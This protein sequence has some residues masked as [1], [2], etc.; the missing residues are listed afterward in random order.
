MADRS[1]QVAQLAAMQALADGAALQRA[2]PTNA[3]GL[4]DRLKAGVEQLSGVSLDGVRVHYDSPEPARLAANAYT[5]GAEIHVGRGNERYLPHETWHVVQQAQGRARPTR[6]AG[7]IGIDDSRELEREADVMGA[8]AMHLAPSTRPTAA[9]LATVHTASPVA[10]LS[11]TSRWRWS[12]YLQGLP[13]NA[14]TCD[15]I[16][17]GEARTTIEATLDAHGNVKKR[18]IRLHT[19]TNDAW[20]ELGSVTIDRARVQPQ[21][22]MPGGGL[23]PPI[24]DDHEL[25]L[26]TAAA[27]GAGNA[28]VATHLFP[29]VLQWIDRNLRDVQ[30]I[31]MN[32]AGGAASKTVIADLGRHV[33]DAQLHG[34]ANAARATRKQA[35]GPAIGGGNLNT[36]DTRLNDEHVHD[37]HSLDTGLAGLTIHGDGM[38]LAGTFDPNDLLDLQAQRD[39]FVAQAHDHLTRDAN[40]PAAAYFQAARA[41]T[42]NAIAGDPKAA[43]RLLRIARLSSRSGA[44]GR[45]RDVDAGYIIGLSGLA[46][47]RIL[48]HA[49]G[50]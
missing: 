43:A 8:R 33:G 39:W 12:G 32:P 4:P 19:Y 50:H 36:W 46:L 20:R 9:P 44:N 26:H 45:G 23:M 2:A 16:D 13:N 1:G 38:R 25:T 31:N 3:T 37:L 10:Q 5:R 42:D 21:G 48:P 15:A 6:Q 49:V 40:H 22:P 7:G 35:G 34:Q 11:L 29:A 41:L 47:A 27:G 28:G 30:Q 17:T 18:T 24:Y 14:V